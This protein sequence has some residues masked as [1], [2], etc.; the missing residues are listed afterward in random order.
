M[1][2]KVLFIDYVYQKGHV[3][4]NRIHI[5][6]IRSAGYDVKIVLHSDIASQLD[7]PTISLPPRLVYSLF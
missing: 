5:D 6:A 2:G 7:Y 1:K 3:N 4:F